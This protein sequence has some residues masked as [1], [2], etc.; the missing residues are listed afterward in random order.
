M[1]LLRSLSLWLALALAGL[2]ITP[3][4]AQPEERFPASWVDYEFGQTLLFQATFESPRPPSTAL[5]FFQGQGDTHTVVGTAYIESNQG[6]GYRLRYLHPLSEYPL[7]PFSH[8]EYRWEVTDAGGKRVKSP[9]YSFYYEDNRYAW[10]TLE[11]APFRVHWFEGEV[12]FAQSVIDAAQRG[13]LEAQKFLPLPRPTSL[14][15]YI[16]PDSQSLEEVLGL[17]GEEWVAGHADPA[18]GVIVVALP[19][20]PD[21][22]ILTQQRIPHELFHVLLYQYVGPGYDNLPVWL[23]EGLASLG[24]LYPNN[25]YDIVLQDAVQRQALLPFSSLCH[26]FPRQASSALLAYAQSASFVRYLYS[27]YGLEGLHSLTVVYANGLGCEQGVQR[28]LR[29]SLSQL[30]RDWRKDVLTED[31]AASAFETL[32][33]WWLLLLLILA[34]SFLLL[35]LQRLQLVLSTEHNPNPPSQ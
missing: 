10:N 13:Y 8:V 24:E 25:D 33:P 22:Y 26:T 3:G 20:T 21:R 14:D 4:L 17:G 12:S 27:L 15:I 16:Y 5:L 29:R 32:R 35:L 2:A 18:L 31:V 6:G 1:L 34:P 11:E 30:E 7:R 28:A 19:A 9:S 23:S